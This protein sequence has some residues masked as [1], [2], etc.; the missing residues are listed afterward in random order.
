MALVEE[1]WERSSLITLLMTNQLEAIF[2]GLFL[3]VWQK[4]LPGICSSRSL[5]F[6]QITPSFVS[7]VLLMLPGVK[8]Q[9]AWHKSHLPARSSMQVNSFHT[10]LFAV[11]VIPR[12]QLT[13]HEW[14]TTLQSFL[15]ETGGSVEQT[16]SN[17]AG[18]QMLT[19]GVA[20][21][22]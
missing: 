14:Y 7:Y 22:S 8:L 6:V 3:G 20:P 19:K 18:V 15:N 5:P 13:H 21:S 1:F 17:S 4:I 2:G 9:D 12:G 16:V 11:L 10:Q